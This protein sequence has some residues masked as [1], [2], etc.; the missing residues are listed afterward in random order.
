MP[1]QGHTSRKRDSAGVPLPHSA[2]KERAQIKRA[3]KPKKRHRNDFRGHSFKML[4][5]IHK[6]LK[7][8]VG[9][10][11]CQFWTRVITIKFHPG[12]SDTPGSLEYIFT[13]EVGMC[14]NCNIPPVGKGAE[15]SL[16]PTARVY[17]ALSVLIYYTNILYLICPTL[18]H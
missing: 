13:S 17:M 9:S 12:K 1:A 7:W 15:G 16:P 10:T 2:F 8:N 18:D 5:T 6:R 11:I 4:S 14:L 3:T